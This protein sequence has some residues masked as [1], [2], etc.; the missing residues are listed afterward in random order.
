MRTVQ[1]LALVA[2]L[3]N[4]AFASAA[5]DAT[6]T[7]IA[8]TERGGE[9][10]CGGSTQAKWKVETKGDSVT[11]STLSGSN[12]T[13]TADLKA[14]QPDGAGRAVGK[15]HRNTEF[16]LTF[17]AGQGPRIFRYSGATIAC[18]FLFTPQK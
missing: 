16:Y 5:Q 15:D 4:F 18:V 6:W 11:I 7:A 17:E 14:L 9:Q 3:T 8:T 1:G 2:A 10:S 13:F 12:R